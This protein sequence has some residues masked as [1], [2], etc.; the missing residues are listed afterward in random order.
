[1]S[2][3]AHGQ[4]D[5]SIRQPAPPSRSSRFMDPAKRIC[6]RCSSLDINQFVQRL[7]SLEMNTSEFA[8]FEDRW[9][10]K[11]EMCSFFWDWLRPA[12]PYH[13]MYAQKDG[14]QFPKKL[15]R[16]RGYVESVDVYCKNAKIGVET[17]PTLRYM[18]ETATRI[19][20][21]TVKNCLRF[22]EENHPECKGQNSTQPLLVIDC[23]TED[24]IR[25]PHPGDNYVTLSYVWGNSSAIG[26]QQQKYLLTNAPRLIKDAIVIVKSLGLR[27]LW[28]DRYCIPQDDDQEKHALIQ[29]MGTIYSNSKLTLVAACANDPNYPIPGV[30]LPRIHLQKQPYLRIRGFTFV[31]AELRL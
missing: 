23:L 22:C 30:M 25:L 3:L 7:K 18:K 12:S 9:D 27:Y 4:P 1:M 10:H 5:K 28:V 8:I 20:W 17:R 19:D 2:I 16:S 14:D 29:K 15:C 6:F 13:V 24:L 26:S 11:C 31:A 21:E